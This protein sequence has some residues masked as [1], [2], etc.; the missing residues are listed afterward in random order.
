VAGV[1]LYTLIVYGLGVFAL[2][3]WP[4]D[5]HRYNDQLLGV[6]A[7]LAGEMGHHITSRDCMS[8]APGPG[9]PA[10]IQFRMMDANGNTPGSP[11]LNPSL[12]TSE[13]LGMVRQC[14]AIITYR[15]D[16][17]QVAQAFPAPA[18]YQPYL[19]ATAD[20][21]HGPNSGYS[22]DRT[23]S[24]SDLVPLGPHALGRYQGLSLTVELYLRGSGQS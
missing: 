24:F 9:W 15:E 17:T 13:Y 21:V 6:T 3:N 20:L 12:T 5:E 23:W 10:S 22:L 18:A 11:P 2:A 14:A 7:S 1:G 16:I 8:Y 4:A 19:R